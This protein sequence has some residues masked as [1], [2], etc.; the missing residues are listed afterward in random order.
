MVAMKK[1]IPKKFRLEVFQGRLRELI[2]RKAQGKP[3]RFAAQAGLQNN[4]IPAYLT[5]RIPGADK[6]WAIAQAGG[7][8]VDWLLGGEPPEES[9][10]KKTLIRYL[11]RRFVAAE[12]DDLDLTDEQI[13]DKLADSLV[14][15]TPKKRGK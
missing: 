2:D 3:S 11:R 10:F 4:E 7:V 5:G 9:R 15:L 12:L 6:V 13:L 14:E 8:S 1:K